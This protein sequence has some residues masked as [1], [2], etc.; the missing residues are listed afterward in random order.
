MVPFLLNRAR[1]GSGRAP[2]VLVVALLIV[3]PL[4]GQKPAAAPRGKPAEILQTLKARL[5]ASRGAAEAVRLDLLDLRRDFPGTPQA[6]EAASLVR[7]LPSPLDRL[8]AGAIPPLERYDWQP[9]G[10]V[11]VLGEHRGRHGNV[12]TAV[13]YSPDGKMVASAGYNSLVRLWDPATLRLRAVL[14]HDSIATGLAFTRDSRVLAASSYAGTVRLWDVSGDQPK[15]LHVVRASSGVLYAVALS[16]DGKRVACAGQDL[17]VRIWDVSGKEPKEW[18]VLS[19]H[20]KLVMA[21]ALSR[22]GRTLASGGYDG[23]VRLWSLTATEATERAVLEAN[24][25]EVAA[26]A[27][28]PEGRTLAAGGHDGTVRLWNLTGN[29]ETLRAVLTPKAGVVYGLAFSPSGKRLAFGAADNHV[30]IWDAAGASSRERFVLKGHDAYVSSVSFSKDGLTLVSG[31]GD[32]TVR[33]WSLGTRPRARWLPR[34]HLSHVYSVAFSPDGKLLASGSNDKTVRLWGL[35]GPD[36]KQRPTLKGEA[37][38]IYSVAISPDGNL[39]A[40]GGASTTVRVWHTASG[41]ETKRLTEFPGQVSNLAFTADGAQVL[42]VCLKNLCLWDARTGRRVRLMEGPTTNINAAALSPDGRRALACAGNYLYQDGRLVTKNN[43]PVYTDCTLRLYDV[44]TGQ[45]LHCF[46]QFDTPVYHATFTADGKQAVSGGLAANV[47]RWTLT[48][49]AEAAPLKGS[50]G[51]VYFVACSPDG[52]AV[53]TIGPDGKIIVWDAA[54]GKRTHEWAIPEEVRTLAYAPDS[55]HL[56]LG[57]GT[58]PVYVLRLAEA[59]KR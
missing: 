56:A 19:G 4:R 17:M 6:V 38:P 33:S 1:A 10:L 57:L 46:T 18:K 3:A 28:D 29:R 51:A 11:A 14:G 47:R 5:K 23:K 42:G 22:S 16:P 8:D 40:G 37:V 43:L 52:K 50:S 59:P 26:V 32:W 35:A 12:V 7:D 44:T 13:A 48:P 55:R 39:V 45:Q 36:F 53:A 27:F 54:S 41:R 21:L 20:T 9:K 31:S 34:G 24:T 25:K 15:L 58:G 49:P 30:H 2:L